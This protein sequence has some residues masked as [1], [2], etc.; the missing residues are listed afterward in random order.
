MI[1]VLLDENFDARI[2]SGLLTQ[3]P[4]IDLVRVQDTDIYGAEDDIVLE[5]AATT[6]RILL[7]H[8]RRTMPNFVRDRLSTERYVAGVFIVPKS[9]GIGSAIEQLVV[10]LGAGKPGEWDN[11]LVIFPIW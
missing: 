3:L 9:I 11:R 2:V 6:E 8:D 5:M 7:T 1:R 4:S 10:A